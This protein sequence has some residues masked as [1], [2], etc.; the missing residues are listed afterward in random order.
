[1]EIVHT[2]EILP[3]THGRGTD[4]FWR[5]LSDRNL[6]KKAIDLHSMVG[7]TDQA[8]A[9]ASIDNKRPSVLNP[10]TRRARGAPRRSEQNPI[11]EEKFTHYHKEVKGR[12]EKI[13]ESWLK[14]FDCWASK[15]VKSTF[16]LEEEAGQQSDTPAWTG[17]IEQHIL[18]SIVDGM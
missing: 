17:D 12:Q 3:C 6:N 2:T 10:P 9:L 11:L 15:R 4:N 1:M 7:W 18:V 14:E 13:L 5:K 16:A 8:L